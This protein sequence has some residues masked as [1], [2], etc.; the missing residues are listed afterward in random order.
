MDHPQIAGTLINLAVLN[1]KTGRRT[2]AE[3]LLKRALII[4]EQKLGADHPDVAITL[5]RLADLASNAEAEPLYKRA[6]AIQEKKLG[7]DHPSVAHTLNSLRGLYL[8]LQ[9]FDEATVVQRRVIAIREKK[10]PAEHP[11]LAFARRS[12]ASLL[13]IQGKSDEAAKL[14]AQALQV[15]R[16]RPR[17]GDITEALRLTKEGNLAFESDEFS[18]AETRYGSARDIYEQAQG[19][20][21]EN[22]AQLW[23]NLSRAIAKQGR[24]KEAAVYARRAGRIRAALVEKSEKK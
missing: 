12:L 8:T 20:D 1:G 15:L 5:S 17:S 23:D 19:P 24:E 10:L 2:E 7:I 9:K 14:E 22:V 4:Q 16:Q 3:L 11:D 21:H 18:R 13:E 6:I